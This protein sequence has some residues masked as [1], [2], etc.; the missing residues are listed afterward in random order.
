MSGKLHLGY[1]TYAGSPTLFGELND[2][3]VGKYCSLATG[4]VFDCGLNHKTSNISTFPFN[5]IFPEK[6]GNIVCENDTRGDIIIGNDVWIG[7]DVTIM[8]GVKIGD[9][10]IIGTKSLVTKDVEPYSIVGG[11][12]ARKIKTRFD[13]ETVEFLQR[14]CWWDW[15]IEEVGKIVPILLSGNIEE[16]K[17][18]CRAKRL[19]NGFKIAFITRSMNVNLYNKMKSLFSNEF[20]F[21]R[22]TSHQGDK[23]ASN[24]LYD[25][26]LNNN[27]DWVINIDEDFFVFNEQA[28]FSLLDYMIENDYDYCGM[29]DGGMCLHRRHSPIVMNPYFNIF[30]AKK[31]RRALDDI[32]YVE[33]F[34]Y[35]E[36][37]YK[38]MPKNMKQNFEWINDNFEPYYPFFYWLPERGFKALYLESYETEDE[39]STII[40]NH[41][42]VE[43]GIHTW[44]TRF[45]DVDEFHTNRINKAFDYARK[46][47]D[48]TT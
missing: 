25:I 45:Y 9:G 19:Y 35:Q 14:I 12:P 44:Y 39:I 11:V 26:I 47:S 46:I 27:Y 29:S 40:K 38:N 20:D 42:N 5:K 10:A 23:G 1:G 3:Y 15:D 16:L 18:Y 13:K 22:N 32:N 48:K 24:Y 7:R 34:A 31:I 17:K 37:M 43:I 28:I 6:Y 30:N 2:V 21:I 41:E 8:S 36:N 4:I 33:T